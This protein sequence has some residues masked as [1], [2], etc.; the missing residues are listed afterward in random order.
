MS[1]A[2]ETTGWDEL[3]QAAAA[4]AAD[5][6]SSAWWQEYI[7]QAKTWWQ[8][9]ALWQRGVAALMAFAVLTVVTVVVVGG[10]MVAGKALFPQER[11]VAAAAPTAAPTATPMPTPTPR[12]TPTATPTP[13]P[14]LVVWSPVGNC[15]YVRPKPGVDD[16]PLACVPNG[17]QV[18]DLGGRKQANGFTWARVQYPTKQGYAATGWMAFGAVAWDFHPNRLTGDKQT[19]LYKDDLASVR[20]YLPPHTPLA[21]VQ[22]GGNGWVRVMLPD[23]TAGYVKAKDLKK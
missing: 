20:M 8:K 4:A 19:P 13:L 12:P 18:V 23:H 11:P 5:T 15:V 14:R 21:V 10:A 2:S 17:T 7:A 3:Q 6:P 1:E 22:D 9:A 16:D